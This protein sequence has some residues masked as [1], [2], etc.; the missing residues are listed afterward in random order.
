MRR[1]ARPIAQS[2]TMARKAAKIQAASSAIALLIPGPAAG[3]RQDWS[4]AARSTAL[5]YCTSR[6]SASPGGSCP[7]SDSAASSRALAAETSTWEPSSAWRTSIEIR[8]SATDRKPL[9]TAA[10]TSPRSSPAP[11]STSRI[12]T[13]LASARIP[14]TGG[15]PVRMPRSPSRVLAITIRAVPDHI[16]PSGA[17]RATRTL[18]SPARPSLRALRS[19]LLQLRG[20]ALHV[21]DPAAH[22]ERLLGD[23]VVLALADRL[24]RGHRVG[25]RHELTRLAGELLGHEHRVREEPLDPPGPL[26]RDLVLFRQLVDA[27]DG[28]DVLQFLVSLQDPLHLA[29]HLVVLVPDVL[30]VQDARGGVERVDRR[31]DALLGHLDEQ[32]VALTGALADPGEHRDA[33]E[34]LGDPGDHL[35]DEHGLADAGA[36]EQADLAALDVRGEQVED[37]DPGL[38]DLRSGLELVERRRVAVDPPALLDLQARRGHVQ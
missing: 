34:V 6:G 5:E 27:E 35:L 3:A 26:D 16:S 32:V 2:T 17:T 1:V 15:C 9:L 33:T 24:E 12:R 7:A 25:Q 30:G 10:L 37:L 8:S 36:A 14:T 31:E 20:L 22:E 29:G 4:P 28:D 18:T 23:V 21:F 38:Q 13:R 19:L 11:S